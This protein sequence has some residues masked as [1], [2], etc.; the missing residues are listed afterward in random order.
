MNKTQCDSNVFTLS[1]GFKAPVLLISKPVDWLVHK[2]LHFFSLFKTQHIPGFSAFWKKFYLYLVVRAEMFCWGVVHFFLLYFLLCSRKTKKEKSGVILLWRKDSP[3]HRHGNAIY[4]CKNHREQEQMQIPCAQCLCRGL[5]T[6]GP[7]SSGVSSGPILMIP[8]YFFNNIYLFL[9]WGTAALISRDEDH[10]PSAVAGDTFLRTIDL[11][12]PLRGLM[13][14]LPIWQCNTSIHYIHLLQQQ[15]FLRDFRINFWW[16][17]CNIRSDA[18]C[19]KFK[20]IIPIWSC[21]TLLRIHCCNN[22]SQVPLG[23]WV[24]KYL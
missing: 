17:S 19:L 8:W 9:T 14:P 10:C 23:L 5:G 1:V 20:S 24:I 7:V 22:S 18:E 16:I 12:L 21:N 6:V 3:E 13:V 2:F 15:P 4:H 11:F